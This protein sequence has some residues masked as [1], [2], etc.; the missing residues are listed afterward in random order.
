LES[1]SVP[2]TEVL[3]NK[4]INFTSTSYLRQPEFA[5]IVL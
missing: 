4:G 1:T 5:K 2:G 3:S